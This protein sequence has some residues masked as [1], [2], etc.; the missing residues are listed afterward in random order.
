MFRNMLR[1][2]QQL[3]EEECISILKKQLRGVLSVHGDDG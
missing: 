3:S 1:I 2:K